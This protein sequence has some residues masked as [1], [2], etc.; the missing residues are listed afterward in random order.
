MM[1]ISMSNHGASCLKY[2][3][4]AFAVSKQFRQLEV[5][6][7]IPRKSGSSGWLKLPSGQTCPSQRVLVSR[8][9]TSSTKV[10]KIIR[11]SRSLM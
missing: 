6:D 2:I 10:K 3:T 1:I 5:E 7:E 9:A 11:D 8:I 4:E